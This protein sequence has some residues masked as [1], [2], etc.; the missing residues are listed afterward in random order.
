MNRNDRKDLKNPTIRHLITYRIKD[1]FNEAYSKQMAM[2]VLHDTF[3]GL[4][5]AVEEVC[6]LHYCED[7][8]SL[9]P[10][11]CTLLNM[12]PACHGVH[13]KS[14]VKMMILF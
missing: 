5:E 11:D 7:Y 6:C 3:T 13:L 1:Y 2:E 4:L 12:G 10:E 9:A 8:P 14:R